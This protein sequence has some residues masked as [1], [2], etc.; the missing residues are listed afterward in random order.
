MSANSNMKKRVLLVFWADGQWS[1]D[2]RNLSPPQ[3]RPGFVHETSDLL[4]IGCSATW[5]GH[6]CQGSPCSHGTGRHA[7][8]V[9]TQGGAGLHCL[10]WGVHGIE[11]LPS[12]CLLNHTPRVRTFFAFFKVPVQQ[13]PL[14][15]HPDMDAPRGCH[16]IGGV[17]NRGGG[18]TSEV[19]FP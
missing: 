5:L 6:I 13:L 9:A 10:R 7:G 3:S 16:F 11:S 14:T 15:C 19:L 1:K 8:R 2:A 12:W 4:P 18:T 17:F